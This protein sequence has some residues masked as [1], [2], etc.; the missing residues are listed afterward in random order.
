MMKRIILTSLVVLAFAAT[1]RAQTGREIAQKVKD[2]PG[3]AEPGICGDGGPAAAVCDVL[4]QRGIISAAAGGDGR[5][6]SG[7]GHDPD[8]AVSVPQPV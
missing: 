1:A 6:R 8:G 2:R 5:Q 3:G 4:R 7:L